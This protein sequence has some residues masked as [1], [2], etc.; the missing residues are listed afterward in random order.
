MASLLA[1][2]SP[3]SVLEEWCVIAST[4]IARPTSST[5]SSVITKS[6]YVCVC[7]C[8]CRRNRKAMTIPHKIS[9]YIQC[10]NMFTY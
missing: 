6:V 4:A 1:T 8:M 3:A 2:I 7:V 5:G 9:R 10:R